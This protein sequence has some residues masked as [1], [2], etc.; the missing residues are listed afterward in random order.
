MSA[1]RAQALWT[2]QLMHGGLPC[3]ASRR[4]RRHSGHGSASQTG[5]LNGELTTSCSLGSLSPLSKSQSILDQSLNDYPDLGDTVGGLKFSC[6]QESVSS[7]CQ[8]TPDRSPNRFPELIIRQLSG[9]LTTT[10]LP[11]SVRSPND[12][13]LI[14][15]WIP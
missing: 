7:N 15:Q 8:S 4:H 9:D 5:K 2:H 14:F 6:P 1:V 13:H 12:P 11:K 3:T 10:Y